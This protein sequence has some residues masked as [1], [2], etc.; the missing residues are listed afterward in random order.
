MSHE[1]SITVQKKR[2]GKWYNLD[3]SGG[4]AGKV[5][6]GPYN[7]EPEASSAARERSR[8][9]PPHKSRWWPSINRGK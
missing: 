7:T 4:N 3:T 8:K 6:G 1:N 2:G 9:T 5:I